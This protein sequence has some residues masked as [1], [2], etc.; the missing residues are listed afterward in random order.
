MLEDEL[1]E[2]GWEDMGEIEVMQAG[3]LENPASEE[4]R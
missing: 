2:E 4:Q 1:G 3:G